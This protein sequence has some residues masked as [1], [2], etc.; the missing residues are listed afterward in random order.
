[1]DGVA[2]T[3]YRA[4][5]DLRRV[6]ARSPAATR[7]AVRRLYDRVIAA[8]GSSTFPLQVWID[9]SGRPRRIA[10]SISLTTGVTLSLNCVVSAYGVPVKLKL[11]PP[12]LVYRMPNTGAA[13]AA[14]RAFA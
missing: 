10:Y 9:G 3:R 1:M 13:A 14:L 4:T 2:T 7:A 12:A 11:P 5:V 8:L 6:I